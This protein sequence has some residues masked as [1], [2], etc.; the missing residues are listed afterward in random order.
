MA[1]LLVRS[2]AAMQ[3]TLAWLLPSSNALPHNDLSIWSGCSGN[4]TALWVLVEHM[5]GDCRRARAVQSTWLR[6]LK[7]VGV[8]AFGPGGGTDWEKTRGAF[9]QALRCFP[10]AEWVAKL[11]DN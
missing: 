2:L 9:Q 11:D 6:P 8:L 10:Q 1:L 5:S 3:A 7:N 4:A